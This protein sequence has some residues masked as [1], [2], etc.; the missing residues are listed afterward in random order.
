MVLRRWRDNVAREV[1]EGVQYVLPDEALTALAT[2]GRLRSGRQLLD[3]VAANLPQTPQL[4][5]FGHCSKVGTTPLSAGDLLLRVHLLKG[6]KTALPVGCRG[7]TGSDGAQCGGL[8]ASQ[9]GAEGE[10]PLDRGGYGRA[11]GKSEHPKGGACLN[12]WMRLYLG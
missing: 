4:H 3:V 1:D 9:Q 11:V 2:G 5:D 6:L 10:L 12:T 7:F 8:C